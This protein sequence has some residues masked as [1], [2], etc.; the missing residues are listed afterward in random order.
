MPMR[1]IYSVISDLVPSSLV[2]VVVIVMAVFSGNAY[3]PVASLIY[4]ASPSPEGMCA[5]SKLDFR[6]SNPV[7]ELALLHFDF[8]IFQVQLQ[9]SRKQ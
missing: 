4:I 5:C 1:C 9:G 2:V 6:P 8:C 7:N 3:S